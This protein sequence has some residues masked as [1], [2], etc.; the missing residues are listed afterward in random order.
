MHYGWKKLKEH[1]AVKPLLNIA[2]ETISGKYCFPM[3]W[4]IKYQNIYYYNTLYRIDLI[5]L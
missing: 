1:F 4:L 5:L 2:A 3:S